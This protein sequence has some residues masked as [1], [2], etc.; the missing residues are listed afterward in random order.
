MIESNDPTA[1]ASRC[2]SRVDVCV[3]EVDN[4][5]SWVH[6]VLKQLKNR[7][8]KILYNNREFCNSTWVYRGQRYADWPIAST[9]QREMKIDHSQIRNV[10]R[11]LRGKE[12]ATI[13]N[14]KAKAWQYVP[15]IEM[16]SLEWLML[17][18]HHGVPT[19][20][21]DF[22]ESP[23]IAL[24]F[25]LEENPPSDFSI[26]ALQRDAMEDAYTQSQIGKQFPELMELYLR[27]GDKT[28]DVLTDV[29]SSDP[30]VMKAQKLFDNFAYSEATAE[31]R[32]C[33]NR[34]LAR[35]VLD[36]PLSESPDIPSNIG[37]IWFYPE[38]PSPR[39]KAQRGLFLMPLNISTPFM[40]ALSLSLHVHEQDT[41]DNALHIKISDTDKHSSE[42]LDVKLIKFVFK[43][44]M[45]DAARDMLLFSNCLHDNLYPDVDGVAESVKAQLQKSLSDYVAF[46]RSQNT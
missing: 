11:D 17:M 33:F 9:F 37:A 29:N 5:Q 25:A 31:M 40:D 2:D 30:V 34:D 7:T 3:L 38:M 45:V 13:S 14:F 23:I 24:F 21:V 44:E 39:M 43:R 15:K 42:L 32:S 41:L 6:F 19:R 18:R 12:H 28:K 4:L 22:T 46:R 27:Y 20:L 16:T 35:R 1:K 36:T 10:E 8:R 26:W